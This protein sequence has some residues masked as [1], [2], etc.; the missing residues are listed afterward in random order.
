V[1]VVLALIALALLGGIVWGI[2]SKQWLVVAGCVAVIAAGVLWV[3]LLL[4]NLQWTYCY[5]GTQRSLES[6]A[7]ELRNYHDKNGSFPP[8]LQISDLG[9]FRP[10]A[11]PDGWGYVMNLSEHGFVLTCLARDGKS[12]GTGYDQDIIVSW[13]AGDGLRIQ[14]AD[15]FP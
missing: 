15:I 14:S 13:K 10:P 4:K 2:A 6:L 3:V 5:S 11:P 8:Q 1:P 9:N 12:G 7:G